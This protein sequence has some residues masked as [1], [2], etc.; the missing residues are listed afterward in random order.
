M[1]RKYVD[2]NYKHSTGS[3]TYVQRFINMV[4]NTREGK[5]IVFMVISVIGVGLAPYYYQCKEVGRKE[6]M[7]RE[8]RKV[9]EAIATAKLSD[10]VS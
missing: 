4:S 5:A 6:Y 10:N 3:G 7:R 8:D 9:A 1:A 2:R